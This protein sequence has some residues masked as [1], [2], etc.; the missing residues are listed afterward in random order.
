MTTLGRKRMTLDICR[1]VTSLSSLLEREAIQCS[2]E[3]SL[4]TGYPDFRP[5]MSGTNSTLPSIVNF[6]PQGGFVSLCLGRGR[7]F[8]K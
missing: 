2:S 3:I 4:T 8:P 6:V 1:Y 5:P 7:A